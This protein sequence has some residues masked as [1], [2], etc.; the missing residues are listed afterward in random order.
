MVLEG[1]E[2]DRE[3]G[4]AAEP[5]LE[6]D[7][8]RLGGGTSA[9]DAGDRG[10]RRRAGGI[11]GDTSAALEE[12]KVVGVTDK[13]V[14]GRN[15]TSLSGE[16]SP[17]LHPVTILTINALAADLNLNLLDEAV[18]DVVEPAETL[19]GRA[20]SNNA[21]GARG[22]IDLREN[23]LDVGLVHQIGVTVDDS[24]DTLVEVGLTVEGNLNRLNREVSV[25]LV[26]NLPESDLRVAG[27]VD[28]LSTVRNKL[29]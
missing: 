12:D 24:R 5:E 17:D 14:E 9:G 22:D 3:A 16:L 13:G 28:I 2:G 20:A 7:V 23:N 18:A 26:E 25:A 29:H 27:N 21:G 11:K 10:L 15:S 19:G 1:D 6:G 4:V 8:E